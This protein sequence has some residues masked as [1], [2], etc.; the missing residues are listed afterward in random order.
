MRQATLQVK[1]QI[2][3]FWA[4]HQATT[5]NWLGNISNASK[6]FERQRPMMVR[7]QPPVPITLPHPVRHHPHPLQPRYTCPPPLVVL[8]FFKNLALHAAWKRADRDRVPAQRKHSQ[9]LLKLR[10]LLI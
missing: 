6:V 5:E 2:P 1:N 9:K 8:S 3:K 10:T 4:L 7:P